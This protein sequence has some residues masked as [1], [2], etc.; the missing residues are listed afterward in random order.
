[1][2]Q[3]REVN[4]TAAR[5]LTRILMA[6]ALLASCPAVARAQSADALFNPDV[7]HEVRLRLNAR[8][9]AQLQLTYLENTHYPCEF[10]WNGIRV[11]NAAVRS[12]GSWTRSPLK[13][14]LRIDFTRYAPERR[15]LGLS[16]LVLD[17]FWNEP[18]TMR[19]ALAMRAIERIGLPA[20]RVAHTRVYVNGRYLGVYA[21]IE[22]VED[23]AYLDRVL[24]EHDGV[25]YEYKRFDKWWF[26]YLGPDLATYA[27]LFEPRSHKTDPFDALYAPIEQLV[28]TVNEADDESFESSVGSLLR[29]DDLVRELAA[30]NAVSDIDGLVGDWGLNNIYLYRPPGG[31]AAVTLPWDKDN[32]FYSVDLSVTFNHDLSVLV[33]RALGIERLRQLY[34]DTVLA[35]TD[36]LEARD[37]EPEAPTWAER[38]IDRIYA[39]VH[40]ALL[41]DPG[42]PWTMDEFEKSVE[43]LREIVRERPAFVRR[44]VARLR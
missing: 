41:D 1:M 18:S 26:E 42:R 24:G 11:P 32:T 7:L 2:P 29:L 44:E 40:D 28:R 6:G 37:D 27:A 17:N 22:S 5:R 39:L 13:P 16:S 30:E 20:S 23:T 21:L 19:E 43:H 10:T 9:W 35:A 14:G 25:L 3:G 8:D 36:V 31:R 34:F 33:R 12:R 15:F 4:M 38:E